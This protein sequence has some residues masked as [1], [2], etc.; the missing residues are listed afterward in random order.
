MDKELC[1]KINSKELTLVEVLVDYNGI[2][3]FFI[4]K[5]ETGGYYVALCT[6]IDNDKY[7]VVK[8]TI[9]KIYNLLTKKM[10]MREI[11]TSESEYWDISAM[12]DIDSDICTNK[13]ISEVD[14]E[15]LPYEKSYFNL[16]T[17][18]HE[19]FLEII[20]NLKCQKLNSL[21][22]REDDWKKL[23]D[24][25]VLLDNNELLGYDATYKKLNGLLSRE[26]DWK[27][28]GDST[29]LLDNNE[30]LGNDTTYKKSNSLI[31]REDDWKKLRNSTVSNNYCKLLSGYV[32]C[33]KMI[34]NDE[35]NVSNYKSI[36]NEISMCAVDKDCVTHSTK[37]TMNN[38]GSFDNLYKD[39]DGL[40]NAA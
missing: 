35:E 7:I 9:G 19:E 32:K 24:S 22:S 39:S 27:K 1:F 5:D 12:D 28:L 4:C 8:T 14:L 16:V 33:K 21:I 10:T 29:V 11:I 6:D 34:T 23:G 3:V 2:P 31:S 40:N 26:D 17:K 36:V 25:T 37:R 15:I 38:S 20:E 18:N 30:L 13:N